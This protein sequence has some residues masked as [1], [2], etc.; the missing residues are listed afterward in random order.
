MEPLGL[1]SPKCRFT[2]SDFMHLIP[3][4]PAGDL[5]RCVGRGDVLTQ[6]GHEFGG[7]AYICMYVCMYI[8]IYIDIG[9]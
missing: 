6:A 9:D 8:Y 3:F 5:L 4:P 1:K 2:R 7:L